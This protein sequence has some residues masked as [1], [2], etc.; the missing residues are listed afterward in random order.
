MRKWLKQDLTRSEVTKNIRGHTIY[1]II[2]GNN[3]N[4]FSTIEFRNVG[5]EHQALSDFKKMF[6]LAFSH[7]ILL[8]SVNTRAEVENPLSIL[9]RIFF[10][11]LI[12]DQIKK[13]LEMIINFRFHFHKKDPSNPCMTVNKGNK[14]SC[15]RDIFLFSKDPI[16]HYESTKMDLTFY[17]QHKGKS[18]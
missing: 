12:L 14:P 10:L 1:Q 3:N 16:F 11:T 18:F 9:R 5:R 4:G 8:R 7:S 2:S 13:L 17:K 6:I 15:P